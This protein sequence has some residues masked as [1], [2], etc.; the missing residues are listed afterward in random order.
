MTCKAE[1]CASWSF[2]LRLAALLVAV[3]S[4]IAALGQ[5]DSHSQADSSRLVE[6]VRHATHQYQNVANAI[7][8]TPVLGCV[9]GPDHGAMGIH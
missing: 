5:P 9:S 7:G 4:P 1:S 8:Y 3:G 6:I 2:H